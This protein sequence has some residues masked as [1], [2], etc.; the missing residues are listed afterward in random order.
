MMK[1]QDMYFLMDFFSSI[2]V[3]LMCLYLDI[4]G[5]L[6]Y[7]SIVKYHSQVNSYIHHLT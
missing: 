7:V 2:D 3:Y 5:D 4:Q 1:D 6:I